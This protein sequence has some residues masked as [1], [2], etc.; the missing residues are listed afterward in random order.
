MRNAFVK[1]LV[2]AAEADERV[3]LLTGDLGFMALE[4]FSERF[5]DRFVNCGVAEQN[6]VGVATGL[7][8]AGLRPFVY[9]IATFSSM[10][11]YEFVRN[12]PVLHGL[13]VCV[14]GIGGGMDYGPNG[15]SH[16][17]IEDVALMRAQPDL[18]VLVPADAAQT[19]DAVASLATL[20]R[21]AYLRLEKGSA[22]VA[23]LDGSF[24]V[25]RAQAIGGGTDVAIV[26]MGGMVHEAV[27]AAALLEDEGVAARVIVVSSF[28]PSPTDDVARMLDGV[29]V[30]VCAESH[31]VHGGLGSFV[32]ETVAEAG[33]RTRVVRLALPST[34]RGKVGS[35]GY[36]LERHGLTGRRIADTVR[37][38]TAPGSR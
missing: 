32:C 4:P 7:A 38:Q 11:A 35:G 3:M 33:L 30:A 14:V 37:Q 19:A 34:P 10:R 20:E 31:L 27:A 6:M 26:A 5:G 23:G 17:A 2:E 36:M 13:P 12:G 29:G 21:P 18:T 1:A 24:R 25:G 28:N 22:A 16:Y 15:A 8:E 9:S